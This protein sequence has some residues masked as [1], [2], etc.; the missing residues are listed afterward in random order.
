MRLSFTLLLYLSYLTAKAQYQMRP[1]TLT[2]RNDETRQG[3]VRYY[4]WNNNPQSIDF[5]DDKASLAQTVPI[6]SIKR[7]SVVDGPVYE[8][9]HLKVPYY[10]KS[11]IS[12]GADL[13]LR[14]DSSYH[15]AE[16]LLDSEPVKLF[17][18]FDADD[19][20][21]FLIA[22]YDSLVL[23][24]DI[25][26]LLAKRNAVYNYNIPE[27]R[28]TLKTVLNECPTLNTDATAYTE[29]GLIALVKEYLSFC[30]IDAKIYSEQKQL[31]KPLIGL[32]AFGSSWRNSEGTAQ[33]YG[34]SVQILLPRRFHNVFVVTDVGR[35]GSSGPMVSS[36]NTVLGLYAGRYFGRGAVQVKAYTG[37]SMVMGPFDTGVGISYRKLISAELRYPMMAGLLGRFRETDDF[38][39]RPLLNFRAIVPLSKRER[40]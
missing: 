14:T 35:V 20:T 28:K 34:V 39:I 2:S 17:R 27:Y 31:S 11:P 23:L 5:A 26:V 9:L 4:D 21:R 22:K 25:H 19:K 6:R 3:V 29:S 8:A 24:N 12:V 16:L 1:A 40:N 30:R 38:F 18:L 36:L 15:F 7:L 33:I 10:A 37:L 32:G 13:I